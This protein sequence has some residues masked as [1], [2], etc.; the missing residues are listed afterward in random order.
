MPD[1]LFALLYALP[2]VLAFRLTFRAFYDDAN[3][4]VAE[5]ADPAIL[6]KN[7]ASAR[8]RKPQ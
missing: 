5:C 6:S 8:S 1:W 7:L 3:K 4:L 2:G